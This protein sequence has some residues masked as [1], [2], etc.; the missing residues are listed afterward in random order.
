MIYAS[1]RASLKGH[2]G[3]SQFSEDY[4]ISQP[5]ECSFVAFNKRR[6]LDLDIDLRTEA[7]AERE[8]A[9]METRP[10]TVTAQVMKALPISVSDGAKAAAEAFQKGESKAVGFSLDN[11][12]KQEINSES[13]DGADLESVK[14]S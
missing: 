10:A 6:N 14:K 12:K 2:L 13:M 5:E 4:F 7:E 8:E 3:G 1:S 9:N 11:S